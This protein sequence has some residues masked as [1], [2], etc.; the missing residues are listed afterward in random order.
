MQTR[1]KA[2]KEGEREGE[3]ETFKLAL[4]CTIQSDMRLPSG[5]SVDMGHSIHPSLYP[6]SPYSPSESLI[7]PL[8]AWGSGGRRCG[9]G[10]DMW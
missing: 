1:L 5:F 8:M 3:R 7:S 9:R 6:I 10:G 2:G 4:K